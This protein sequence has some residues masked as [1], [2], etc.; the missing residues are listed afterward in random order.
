MHIHVAEGLDDVDAPTR[1]AGL[2][3]DDWLLVHGVHLPDAHGLAGTIVHNPR[4][5][6]NNAVGSADVLALLRRRED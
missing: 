2:T 6:M 3:S 1:L 4:S 5:N